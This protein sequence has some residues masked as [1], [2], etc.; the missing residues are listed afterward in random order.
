MTSKLT[1]LLPFFFFNTSSD[2]QFLQSEFKGR[3]LNL[4]SNLS[5]VENFE[6]S[7]YM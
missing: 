4:Y 1:K 6:N 5:F 2:L 3:I 7:M